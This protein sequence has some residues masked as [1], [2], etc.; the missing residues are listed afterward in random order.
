MAVGDF[1]GDGKPDLAVSNYSATSVNIL[2][3]DGTGNFT[4]VPGNPFGTQADGTS[5]AVGDFD[6]DGRT[7]LAMVGAFGNTGDVLLGARAFTATSVMA[8]VNSAV[9]YGT[10]VTFTAAVNQSPAGFGSAATGTVI[11]NATGL[12]PHT[13]LASPYTLTTTSLVPGSYNVQAVYQGDARGASSSGSVGVT[14]TK[15]NEA[16]TFGA[17]SDVN[18]GDAPFLVSATV[19]VSPPSTASPLS[20]TFVSNTTA[21]CTVNVVTNMVTIVGVGQC[22]ISAVESGNANLNGAIVTRLFNVTVP[23]TA[24]FVALDTTTQG[25][26]K[27]VYGSEGEAINGDSAIYPG[28]AAVNFSGANPFVWAASAS[29]ARDLQ[30]ATASGRI[31]S[32]WYTSSA[33]SF[34]VNLTDGNTHQ[35]AL[36]MLDWDGSSRAERV[37]VLD[38]ISQTVLDTRTVSGFHNGEYLVW[39]L[40]G[41]VTL[42]IT[43]TGGGNAVASGLFFGPPSSAPVASFVALDTTTQGTWKGVYGSEGEAINGDSTNYPA[44]AAVNFSGA[45]PFVWAASASEVRDLQKAAAS[46]RIAS[47][48]YTSS[49]MSF[50]VNLTDGNTHQVALYFLDWDG[51]SRA[52]RV[53]VLDAISQTVLDTRTVSGFHNGEYLVWNLS[54]HVTVKI[55]LTGGGNAVASGLFFGPPSSAPWAPTASVGVLDTTTQG[56]WKGTYGADGE[57][58]R[59]CHQRP[60]LRAGDLQRE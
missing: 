36:Y 1:D 21:V 12:G 59:G 29:E 42:R 37:D 13:V 19:A 44:Y 11:F 22:S 9:P 24:S 35:V 2:L 45:N 50:D 10:P 30:K 38:A 47:G 51:S 5:I 41:H 33:M 4:L 18:F 26:W 20:L 60:G 27:G 34:D 16:I 52:E 58:I 8:S 3:G 53:D 17:L 31:A 46:D 7:D 56:T 14:V 39:N 15:A 25:T 40:H 48:W 55:T 23:A 49:A 6:G 54:G 32:G 57:V 43:L 28:Y